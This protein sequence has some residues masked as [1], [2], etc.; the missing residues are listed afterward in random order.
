MS[1]H[2]ILFAN[3]KIG[4]KI[5]KNMWIGRNQEYPKTFPRKA[6]FETTML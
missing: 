3:N 5:P 2:D 6:L 1:R 4:F